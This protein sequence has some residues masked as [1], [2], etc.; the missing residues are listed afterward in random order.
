M[1]PAAVPVHDEHENQSN[2]VVSVQDEHHDDQDQQFKQYNATELRAIKIQG[3]LTL[4]GGVALHFV[5]GT[6]YLWG[7]ISNFYYFYKI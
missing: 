6:F 1:K 5:L 4:I 7:G 2:P 3:Y